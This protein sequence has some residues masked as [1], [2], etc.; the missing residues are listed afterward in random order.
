MVLANLHLWEILCGCNHMSALLAS[1]LY[2]FLANCLTFVTFPH[3]CQDET[4]IDFAP[5]LLKH[6]IVF[7]YLDTSIREQQVSCRSVDFLLFSCY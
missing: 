2:V 1:Y 5:V 3:L 4:P 7:G 6:G